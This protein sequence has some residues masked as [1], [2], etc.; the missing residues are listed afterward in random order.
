MEYK[1]A[2]DI[3]A[4]HKANVLK[5]NGKG[6]VGSLAINL[7]RLKYRT[8]LKMVPSPADDIDET[9][10][11]EYFHTP[12]ITLH[13]HKVTINDGGWFSHSTHERLNEYMPRGFRVSGARPR[14]YHSTV[15]FIHTPAGTCAYNL[16]KTFLYSGL[17][18]DS[19]SVYAGTC[20]HKI[21]AYV[22]MVLDKAFAGG[23]DDKTLTD[24]FVD[25]NHAL[26]DGSW[27]VVAL[28]HQRFRPRMLLHVSFE[29][30]NAGDARH[31]QLNGELLTDILDVMCLEGAQVF[32]TPRSKKELVRRIEAA[33]RHS[34]EIPI[35]NLRVLRT[36]LRKALIEFLVT[37]LGFTGKEWNRR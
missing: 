20:L 37:E 33:L 25:G 11:I 15:G 36:M 6:K 21:P 8:F 2:R 5:A 12:I 28:E 17:P 18:T 1:E 22:D 23:I 27:P 10:E 3:M 35:V 14:W 16:P 32:T 31:E 34:R 30:N 13:S 9:Y 29:N 7:K 19:G 4:R 26:G 24:W